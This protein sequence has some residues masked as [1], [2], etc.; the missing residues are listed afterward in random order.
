MSKKIIIFDLDDT[1]I[2]EKDYIKSGFDIIS[3]EIAKKYKM[4][5]DLIRI[6]MDSLFLDNSN[7]LFNRL[8]D[9]FDCDY[10]Q[11]Y[12]KYLIK[13]YRNHSPKIKLYDDAKELLDY[14]HSNNYQMGLITDGYKEAQRKKIEILDIEKYFEYIVV[15]D[16]LGREFW[17]PS[18]IPYK[19]IKENFKCDYSDMV[20]I[21]D[22]IEK[23]F[24]T[25]NRLGIETF[26][27]IRDDGVYRNKIKELNYHAKIKVSSLD[28][29]KRYLGRI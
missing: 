8:L 14:L 15:T 3:E 25:A 6:K 29:I 16:E 17:K 9:N 13:I 18:E 22:N 28:E 12:I 11:E 5:I 24:V 26:H 1:L 4:E 23:D 10:D 20:Y 2:S 27:I 7:N 19:I 21:G